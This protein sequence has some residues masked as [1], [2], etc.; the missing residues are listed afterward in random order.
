MTS[1]RA[2]EFPMCRIEKLWSDEE[3]Q[4]GTR[5]LAPGGK[6]WRSL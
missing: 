1:N 5:E 6:N 2:T 4:G 3:G